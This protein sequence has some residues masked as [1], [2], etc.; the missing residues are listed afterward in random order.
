MSTT[1]RIDGKY[2]KSP[3]GSS[4]VTITRP[5]NTTA[6]GAGDVFGSD[7]AANIEFENVVP[8][9]GGHLYITDLKLVVALSA[10]PA[11]MAA[12][13]LHLYDAEPTAIVDNAAWTLLAADASK[14][15]GSIAITAPTDLGGALVTWEKGINMKRKCAEDV[16][17]IFGVLVTD[18]GYTPTSEE[19][20]TLQL[21][22]V[23]A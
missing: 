6:Y 2:V 9:P 18:A 3:C 1:R 12:W 13:T 16:S 20:I 21:E 4:S 22:T 8:T 17:S 19:E 10:V 14:Y 23:V 15:L 7:P 11:G 5:D